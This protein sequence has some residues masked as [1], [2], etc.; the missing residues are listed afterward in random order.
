MKRRR[1]DVRWMFT[2]GGGRIS[3]SMETS[4]EKWC[5]GYV[6]R[7]R[8]QPSSRCPEICVTFCGRSCGRRGNTRP[9]PSSSATARGTRTLFLRRSSTDFAFLSPPRSL[10]Y[11]YFDRSMDRG[12]KVSNRRYWKM[13]QSEDFFLKL[14]RCEGS[15]LHFP[16]TLQWLIKWLLDKNSIEFVSRPFKTAKVSVNNRPIWKSLSLLSERTYLSIWKMHAHKS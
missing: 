2:K 10:P 5:A 4:G 15:I 16:D 3:R 13:I 7:A 1:T 14:K 9:R 6:P 11:R 12:F 8:G